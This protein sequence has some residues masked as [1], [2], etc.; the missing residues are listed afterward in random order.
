MAAA[1]ANRPPITISTDHRGS[2]DVEEPAGVVGSS[3]SA[4]ATTTSR[5]GDTL[6]ADDVGLGDWV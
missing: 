4:D 6:V 2:E 5:A 3:G 1:P